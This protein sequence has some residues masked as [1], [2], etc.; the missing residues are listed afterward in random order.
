[1]NKEEVTALAVIDDEKIIE[2]TDRLKNL[3][4]R[5]KCLRV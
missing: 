1:M 4:E 5:K 3:R 2:E